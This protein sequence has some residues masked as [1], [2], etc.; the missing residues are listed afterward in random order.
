[1]WYIER[2]TMSKWT[3]SVSYLADSVD[4]LLEDGALE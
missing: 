4:D 1:M 2:N 3:E